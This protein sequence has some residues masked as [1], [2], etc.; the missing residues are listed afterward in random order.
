[1]HENVRIV[2]QAAEEEGFAHL[3]P[4]HFGI[5]KT[6]EEAASVGIPGAV[7]TVGPSDDG[8][9]D[10][11]WPRDPISGQRRFGDWFHQTPG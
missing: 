7:P 6:A 9:C 2:L 8:G 4:K 5:P 3:L 10:E 1:M 11:D